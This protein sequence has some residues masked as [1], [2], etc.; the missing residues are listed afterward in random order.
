MTIAPVQDEYQD[1]SFSLPRRAVKGVEPYEGG[2]G[3]FGTAVQTG[4]DVYA[5]SRQGVLPRGGYSRFSVLLYPFM[6]REARASGLPTE[7]YWFGERIR[8]Y[9]DASWEPIDRHASLEAFYAV[10]RDRS[11]RLGVCAGNA[12]G[13][14]NTAE[15]VAWLES[16]CKW[17]LVSGPGLTGLLPSGLTG[18]VSGPGRGILIIGLLA[19]VAIAARKLLF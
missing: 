17:Q 9:P 18:L 10:P 4:A 19:V 15:F 1:I 2:G 6:L 11:V 14:G 12:P 8:V 3:W 5:Q 7:A 13:T 16:S